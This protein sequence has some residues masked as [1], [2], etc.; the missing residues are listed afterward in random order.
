M[1]S[2]GGAPQPSEGL[3]FLVVDDSIDHIMVLV[4]MLEIMGHT[5]QQA[6]SGEQALDLFHAQRP[7]FVLMDVLMPGMGGY[8]AV[9]EMRR[10]A[11]E[12]F[13]IIF[14]T[15]LGRSDDA[16]RGFEAGG[17]DFLT[18]PIDLT[19]LRAKIHSL[20]VRLQLSRKLSEQNRLLL[21]YQ[22]HN[23]EEQ[24]V[25][26]GYMQRMTMQHQLDDPD[27]RY[28]LRSAANLSGDLIAV[29]R[30]PEGVLHLLLAD[31]TGHGLSAALAA[32]P[33]IHPFYSMTSKSFGIAAIAREMNDKVRQVLPVS[34]FVAA[35]LAAIDPVTQTVEVWSGG[36]P[37][38]VMLGQDGALIHAFNP[39][40]LA[41][42]ILATSEFDA[43]LQRFCY[44]GLEC[45]LIMF[46]DGVIEREGQH[47]D[48]FGLNRLLETAQVPDA[49][50]GREIWQRILAAS[51]IFATGNAASDD[52]ALMQV[53]CPNMHEEHAIALQAGQSKRRG[54]RVWIFS[55]SLHVQQIRKMDVVP[56]LLDLVQK[57]EMDRRRAGE[58]FLVLSELFN[59]A[60]DHGLLKLDS[61]LKHHVSGMERYFDERDSR[62]AST[63]SGQVEV[64]LEKV[65]YGQGDMELRIR[66]HDS[67]EG[68]DYQT[69]RKVIASDTQRHGRGI[70]LVCNLCSSVE[71]M[72][73]GSEVLACLNLPAPAPTDGIPI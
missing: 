30:T 2:S 27:V 66:V 23:E 50:D 72:G 26:A 13:P 56:L 58:I 16:V 54:Q 68:F 3:R 17:D 37:P 63:R 48:R 40:H 73:N 55:V 32:M 15:G 41:L 28:F 1:S 42:G 47:G 14:I 70:G 34:H 9:R 19:I 64:H 12:W 21:E 22:K 69:V 7:D 18:H 5:V 45:S 33:V 20:Q 4:T 11:P 53:R 51:D 38:P 61:S 8:E 71:Y 59:N 49:M 44:R 6:M 46:T 57:I 62:L 52:M 35:I 36:C 25:A 29:A 24:L 43:A 31:S 10:L 65:L 39:Q 60:V 67:G